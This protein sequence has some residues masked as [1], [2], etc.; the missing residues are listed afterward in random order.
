MTGW[1]LQASTFQQ[2]FRIGTIALLNSGI[3][4]LAWVINQQ[5]NGQIQIIWV[6]LCLTILYGIIVKIF[7]V[8][9]L[10]VIITF[11]KSKFDRK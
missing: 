3:F 6:M 4:L 10:S 2:L 1:I 5:F 9:D 7:F 8:K 11:I